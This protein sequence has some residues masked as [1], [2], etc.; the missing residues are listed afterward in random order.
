MASRPTFSSALLLS[1]V[2]TEPQPL[3]LEPPSQ[4]SPSLPPPH[5][6]PTH[7]PP[8]QRATGA[9]LHLLA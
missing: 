6:P 8:H 5:S 1:K 9:S 4:P 3:F 7:P 2:H